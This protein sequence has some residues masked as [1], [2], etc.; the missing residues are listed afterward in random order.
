MSL[1]EG[2]Q[3]FKNIVVSS[4]LYASEGW[5]EATDTPKTPKY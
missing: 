1:R 4:N 5:I 2:P 3:F